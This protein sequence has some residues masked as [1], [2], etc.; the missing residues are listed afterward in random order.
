MEAILRS[1]HTCSIATHDQAILDRAYK[2]IHQHSL[3]C[4]ASEFEMLHGVTP[5]RLQTMQ[6]RGYHTR[7]YLPYG[8]EWYLYLCHRLAEYPPNLYQAFAEVVDYR[9]KS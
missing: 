9:Y 6:E 7:I 8:Q 3:N 5:E 4:V 1:G 2:Y